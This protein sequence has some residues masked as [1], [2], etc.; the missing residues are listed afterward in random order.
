MAFFP[1]GGPAKRQPRG[2]ARINRTHPFARGLRAAFVGGVPAEIVGGRAVSTSGLTRVVSNGLL[3]H[4]A[5]DSAS[6]ITSAAGGLEAPSAMTCFAIV[7][8]QVGEQ[9]YSA[10]N[11]RYLLSTRTAGNAG[12]A[13]GRLGAIGGGALGNL[14]RQTFVVQGVALYQQSVETVP[15]LCNSKVAITVDGTTLTFYDDAGLGGA[16]QSTGSTTIGSISAGENLWFLAQGNTS[17]G[18]KGCCALVFAW[19]RV[20]TPAELQSISRAPWQLF[21]GQDLFF[22]TSAAGGLFRPSELSG[23]GSGGARFHNPLG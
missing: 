11:D 5:A 17:V 14:T 6:G 12:W 23:L 21:D 9:W 22:P 4:Q 3:S 13:W 8:P 20:L 1:L 7:A 2:V 16:V 10:D 15:S 18:W 19:N